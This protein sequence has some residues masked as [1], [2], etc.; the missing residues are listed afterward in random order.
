MSKNYKLKFIEKE[1]LTSD[2]WEF[3][4]KKPTG[5]SFI[6]GQYMEYHLDH[7]NPDDRGIKRWFTISSSPEDNVI[8][9]TTRIFNKMSS[10]KDALN[11]L[12]IGQPIEAKGPDG[13]FTLNHIKSALLIAGGIG[14]T[15]YHSQIKSLLNQKNNSLNLCLLYAA[16]EEQGLVYD[17]V[18]IRAESE[19]T[20]FTYAKVLE[21][22]NKIGTIT[23]LVTD[24]LI[25]K[26]LKSKSL[27]NV[28]I[29]GPEPMVD[30]LKPRLLSI[31][32]EENKIHQD[33][34]PNYQDN[35]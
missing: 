7:D 2:I 10:F 1:H 34:F 8:T 25:S 16:K 5:F 15:P 24:D 3:R 18:F 29:S 27:D 19:F 13:D 4:F 35:F 17:D 9:I 22:A 23:G 11:N 33:W 30:A 28:Y 21:K 32:V 26:L 12:S 14:V 31:G 20:D 6:P